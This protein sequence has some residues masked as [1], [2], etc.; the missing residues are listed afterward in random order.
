MRTTITTSSST[1][2]A[3][4]LTGLVYAHPPSRA[5]WAGCMRPL[6][7]YLER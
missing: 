1:I 5:K 3:V 4:W 7:G 2:P 6:I